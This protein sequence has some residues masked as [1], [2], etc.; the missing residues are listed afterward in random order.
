[1]HDG[2]DTN[3]NIVPRLRVTTKAILGLFQLYGS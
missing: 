2:M 1:M 3:K